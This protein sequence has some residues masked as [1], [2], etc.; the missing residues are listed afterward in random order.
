MS[1]AGKM[2]DL[3]MTTPNLQLARVWAHRAPG[4]AYFNRFHWPSPR[5]DVTEGWLSYG[6]RRSF[7][8]PSGP[9]DICPPQAPNLWVDFEIIDS[10]VP[11]SCLW[12]HRLFWDVYNS[13]GCSPDLWVDFEIINTKVFILCFRIQHSASKF[14]ES[15]GCSPRAVSWFWNNQH[16]GLHLM[17]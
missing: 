17:L 16:K 10:L 5:R 12:A 6:P 11:G 9:G 14:C 8:P 4:S 13:V 3:N 15:V 7:R 2:N 1:G